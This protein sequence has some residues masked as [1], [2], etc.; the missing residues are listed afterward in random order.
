MILITPLFCLL[1]VQAVLTQ[2]QTLQWL[3]TLRASTGVPALAEDALLSQTSLDWAKVLA[4]AGVISH[5][6][7]D[8]SNSLD[9]YRILGGTEA[10]VGE[11]I[12]AGPVLSAIEQGWERSPSH[13]ALVLRSFWTHAGVGECPT[14]HGGEVCVVMVCQKQVDGL[15]II[16]QDDLLRVSGRF[17]VRAA[18][19]A[20]L[21]AGLEGAKPESW[22][23]DSRRFDF[24]LPLAG[25]P[26]YIRL[27][28]T[29]G[30][31]RFV[32][33]NAFTWRRGTGFP[34]RKARSSARR[35]LP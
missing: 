14:G 25:L 23:P 12:G 5:M 10:R 32:L 26:S 3:N 22:D 17:T 11:I 28:F 18:V 34:V 20:V 1:S 8:G 2:A 29:A 21:L 19:N 6:G 27:G 16:E 13:R 30:D 33:T 9:R 4:A 35:A 7:A 31:G 24:Q 15:Q